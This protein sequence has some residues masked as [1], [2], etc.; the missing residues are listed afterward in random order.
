MLTAATKSFK[1]SVRLESV[2]RF[3]FT[4]ARGY[5]KDCSFPDDELTSGKYIDLKHLNE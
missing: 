1:S 2:A 4:A 3:D 5:Y